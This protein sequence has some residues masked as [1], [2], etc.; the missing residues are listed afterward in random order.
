MVGKTLKPPPRLRC[1]LN[2]V[3]RPGTQHAPNTDYRFKQKG[4]NSKELELE[5]QLSRTRRS[6]PQ[7]R[8][9]PDEIIDLGESYYQNQIPKDG[10][11]YGG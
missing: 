8:L 1:D 7:V 6:S 3:I 2:L 4:R 5:L 10:T 9:T 11:S